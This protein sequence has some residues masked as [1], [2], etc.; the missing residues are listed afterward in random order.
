MNNATLWWIIA[1]LLIGA[2]LASARAF[3]QDAPVVLIG[4]PDL[5]RLYETLLLAQGA[6]PTHQDGAAL[7]LAGLTAAHATPEGT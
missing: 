4:A 7:V 6:R 1:A 2:E 5:T 3:W